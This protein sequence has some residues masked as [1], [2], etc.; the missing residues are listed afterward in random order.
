[1]AVRLWPV[2]PKDYE[3]NGLGTI[4]KLM[5]D[6]PD[7]E[8]YIVARINRRRAT[9]DDEKGE[10]VPTARVL[11]IEP[12]TGDLEDAARELLNTAMR[13]RTKAGT[14]DEHFDDGGDADGE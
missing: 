8:F 3:D 7:E 10:T 13:N 1:M 5:I 11:H 6:D 2:L 9:I 12:A 4:E 14:L